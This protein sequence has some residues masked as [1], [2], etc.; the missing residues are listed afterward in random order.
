MFNAK[1]GQSPYQHARLKTDFAEPNGFLQR[2]ERALVE[3]RTNLGSGG[4]GHADHTFLRMIL[5]IHIAFDP[6]RRTGV[7][8]AENSL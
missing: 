3:L 4:G 7:V 8:D 2:V 1:N 5:H 6:A